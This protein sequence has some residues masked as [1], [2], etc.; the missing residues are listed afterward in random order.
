[1]EKSDT[2]QKK[3]LKQAIE[4]GR[5]RDYEKAVRVLKTLLEKT[6]RFPEAMLYLAR[7]YHALGKY[8]LSV[9]YCSLYIERQPKSKSGY[10]FM[11]RSLLSMGLSKH[12]LHYLKLLEKL[13]DLN[14]QSAALLGTALLKQKMPSSAVRYFGIAL[15]KE[16]ENKKY[17][18]AY[19]NALAVYGIALFNN[20]KIDEAEHAFH[21]AIDY[22]NEDIL[23]FLYLGSIAKER[24][25]YAK[26]VQYYD[27]CLEIEPQDE[28]IRLQ[29]ALSVYLAGN[30]EE[31]QSVMAQI[32]NKKRE[33]PHEKSQYSKKPTLREM[34]FSLYRSKN[35]RTALQY[36]KAILRNDA[37]DLEMR[38]LVAESFYNIGELDK[39]ENHFRYILRKN[40]HFRE[41]FYGL[42]VLLWE[43][44]QYEELMKVLNRLSRYFPNDAFPG[45]YRV[46]CSIRIGKPVEETLPQVQQQIR[47]HGPDIFLMTALGN[48][49]LRIER[50]DLAEG[51][52]F[53]CLSISNAFKEARMGLLHVYEQQYDSKAVRQEYERYLSDFPDDIIIRKKLI[54][55]LMGEEYYTDAE[56][57]ILVILPQEKEKFRL[58]RLLAKIYRRTKR[59]GDAA[60]LYR[61]LLKANPDDMMLLKGLIFC[62]EH[63]KKRS[64]AVKILD[65]AVRYFKEDES[66]WL[67]LGV[68]KYRMDDTEGAMKVFRAILSFEPGSWRAYKNIGLVYS[69]MGME[70]FAARFFKRAEEYKNEY[71]DV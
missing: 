50:A 66:L 57:H 40:S 32:I 39:A 54:K 36:A 55:M 43:T 46:L 35:Y 67:I 19:S 47:V 65:A 24:Q 31:A 6:D 64:E 38:F 17:H 37:S 16:P 27:R 8:R 11:A 15:E 23:L 29:R 12:A 10:F 63:S 33:T 56:K 14:S 51:W 58:N 9:Q 45:Y 18:T 69:R 41:A 42:A 52:F 68:L 21:E 60:S 71:K 22:G 70:D 48:E 5:K 59:Y 62:L 26:A 4:L 61:Q 3:L 2:D 1:M 13:G 34:A 28:G 49:Y 44:E 53:R 30:T 7:S 20:G 25:D